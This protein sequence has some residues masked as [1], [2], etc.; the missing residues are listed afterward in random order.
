MHRDDRALEER[1]SFSI[2]AANISNAKK[3]GGLKLPR[4]SYYPLMLIA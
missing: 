2:P 3:G 4:L 1:L